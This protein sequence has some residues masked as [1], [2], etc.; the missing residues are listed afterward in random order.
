MAMMING[1]CICC[2]VCLPE[3]PNDAIKLVSPEECIIDPERCGECVGFYDT[4]QCVE[5]CPVDAVEPLPA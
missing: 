5:V 1:R 4:P 2:D 3:C